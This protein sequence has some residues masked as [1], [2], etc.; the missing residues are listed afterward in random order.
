MQLRY[1]PARIHFI[2]PFKIAHGVR[3]FTSLVFVE[4]ELDGCTGYGEASLPPYLSENQQSV[5]AFLEL[6]RPVLTSCNELSDFR[7]L[8]HQ[9]DQL[10][11]GQTAAKAA[12]DIAIHDLYG[13]LNRLA[14]R[15]LYQS[16]QPKIA[17]S[18]MTIGIGSEKELKQKL[19]EAADFP[20][21]KVKLDGTMDREIISCI[22]SVTDKAIAVDINQGWTSTEFAIRQIEWL[23]E[24]SVLFVEQPLPKNDIDGAFWLSQRSPLPLYADESV[25]GLNDLDTIRTV[26]SG[27][28]I[29][30]MKCGGLYQ[31]EKMIRTARSYG[32]KVLLGCMSES[33]CAVTAAAQL[34][35]LTDYNDLDGPLLIRDDPFEGIEFSKG[36]IV[37]KE[38]PGTG[39]KPKIL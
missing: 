5:I 18:T 8:I 1:R 38:L 19:S 16:G 28:N 33:S 17:Y 29:K 3:D 22:R 37:L 24:Q 27:I 20:L 23:A 2:H 10:A 39:V 30:L 13:K 11:F 9:L 15:D 6:A 26:Y 7:S 32:L 34:S 21:L 35:S 36:K 31:A 12:L 25:Q 4:L 14:V